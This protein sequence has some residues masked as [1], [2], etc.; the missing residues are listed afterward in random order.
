MTKQVFN[1]D[2]EFRDGVRYFFYRGEWHQWETKSDYQRGRSD[3]LEQVV[4]WL[5]ANLWLYD[6]ELG[7][8]YIKEDALSDKVIDEEMVIED[9]KKAMRPQQQENIQ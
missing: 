4:E 1:G 2:T 6:D 3:M 5:Q 8:I 9:L 7:P